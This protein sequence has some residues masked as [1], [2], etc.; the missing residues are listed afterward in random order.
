[1]HCNIMENM[2]AIQ[3]I[4]CTS[5]DMHYVNFLF[6]SHYITQHYVI[7]KRNNRRVKVDRI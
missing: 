3:C 6:L 7:Y 5:L 1:M 4:K 2:C